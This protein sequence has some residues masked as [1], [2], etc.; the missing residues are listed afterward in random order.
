MLPLK[1]AD[2][3]INEFIDDPPPGFACMSATI[4]SLAFQTGALA[5]LSARPAHIDN[6]IHHGGIS[7]LSMK[8]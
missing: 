4:L 1:G 7:I 3:V 5:L 2:T 6:A 8:V